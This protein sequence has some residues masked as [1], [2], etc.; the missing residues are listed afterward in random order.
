MD[1]RLA[2]LQPEPLEHAVHP[3]GPEDPHQVVFQ[4]EEELGGAGIALTAGT[5]AK[6]VVD[7]A[8]LVPLGADHEQAAGR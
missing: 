2:F 1:D 4:A 8:A 3:L 6:L 5:A 7:A